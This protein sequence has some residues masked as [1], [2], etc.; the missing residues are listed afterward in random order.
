M[1]MQSH[2]SDAMLHISEYVHMC[3]LQMGKLQTFRTSRDSGA[4]AG[5]RQGTVLP[6]NTLSLRTPARQRGCGNDDPTTDFSKFTV[7]KLKGTASKGR[8]GSTETKSSDGSVEQLQTA[9]KTDTLLA[10]PSRAVQGPSKVGVPAAGNLDHHQLL[11]TRPLL[12]RPASGMLGRS[13]KPPATAAA[14]CHSAAAAPTDAIAC[15]QLPTHD[16][17]ASAR[18][19]VQPEEAPAACNGVSPAEPHAAAVSRT[20]SIPRELVVGVALLD[21]EQGPLPGLGAQ[22]MPSSGE[23]QEE[24]TD[25]LPGQRSMPPLKRS[26]AGGT[27]SRLV[28]LHIVRLHVSLARERERE[29]DGEREKE[30]KLTTSS[31]GGW[32]RADS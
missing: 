7:P 9:S 14:R 11:V 28:H 26:A 23:L 8:V 25:V 24:A 22:E 32:S 19:D 13:S 10:A 5:K 18:S 1:R 30:N 3:T 2:R 12:P 20:R 27:P 16:A 31:R 15:Q 6:R 4:F 17:N 21:L 29:R